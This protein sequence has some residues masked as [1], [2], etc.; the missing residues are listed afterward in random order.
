MSMKVRL[1]FGNLPLVETAIR[2]SFKSGIDLGF[3]RITAIHRELQGSFPL[4][5]E[6]KNYEAAPGIAEQIELGPGQI[7][8]VV[9][10]GNKNGLRITLQRHVVVVR[11]V[12][13]PIGDSPIYPRYPLLRKTLW[14]VV[15]RVKSVFAPDFL[16]AVVN[17]SYVNFIPVENFASVLSD[18]F[19]QLVHVQALDG[20]DQIMKVEFAWREQITGIEVRFRLEKVSVP[21][22]DKTE[23]GCR[24][25]TI[26]GKHIFDAHRTADEE[27]DEVHA[28]LQ[29]FFRDALSERAK[30]EW[31]LKEVPI[32]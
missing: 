29:A 13:Q 30:S 12:K 2:A 15:A 25:T 16:P 18:Y 17:M 5:E 19:S 4:A 9:F 11:W 3:S 22:N 31:D 6:L 23:D 10:A 28:R 21:I 8:G 1:D 32:A 7:H 26:A 24:L 20:A 14:D 27:L